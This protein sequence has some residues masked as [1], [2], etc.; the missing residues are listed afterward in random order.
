MSTFAALQQTDL[1]VNG[2][3]RTVHHEAGHAVMAMTLGF[4]V[5]RIVVVNGIA[6][7]GSTWIP[8]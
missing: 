1:V 4:P 2:P 3:G 7:S 8:C 6:T 5:R